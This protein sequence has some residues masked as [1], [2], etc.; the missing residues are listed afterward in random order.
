MLREAD[1]HRAKSHRAHKS[2]FIKHAAY[3]IIFMCNPKQKE[4]TISDTYLNCIGLQTEQAES[5]KN[6][7]VSRA[8]LEIMQQNSTVHQF[9]SK[10]KQLHTKSA[11]QKPNEILQSSYCTYFQVLALLFLFFSF[12][13]DTLRSSKS[14][15]G[16]RMKGDESLPKCSQLLSSDMQIFIS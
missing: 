10:Y 2:H 14:C 16:K 15:E 6:N 13:K 7:K 8:V 5:S 1:T 11:S 4:S 3:K 9:M 12:P